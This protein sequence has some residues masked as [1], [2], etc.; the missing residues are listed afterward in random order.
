MGELSRHIWEY[1]G[2][3]ELGMHA[4]KRRH[5]RGLHALR[6]PVR[7]QRNAWETLGNV[8]KYRKREQ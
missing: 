2:K 6:V 3:H 4:E 7:E 8:T 5:R 1:R